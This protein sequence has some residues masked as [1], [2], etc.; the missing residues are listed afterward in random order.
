[1]IDAKTIIFEHALAPFERFLLLAIIEDPTLL[2]A[3]QS[4]ICG[5]LG[6]SERH[7]AAAWTRFKQM[8]IFKRSLTT[9][10]FVLNDPQNWSIISR[11]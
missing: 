8:R 4:Q 3:T 6:I 5:R 2:E 10:N 1:M 9:R 11:P 7:L